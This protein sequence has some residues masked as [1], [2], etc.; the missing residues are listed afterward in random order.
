[1]NESIDGII[2]DK[3]YTHTYRDSYNLQ[4]ECDACEI[5][6]STFQVQYPDVVTFLT[7][8]GIDPIYPLEAMNFSDDDEEYTYQ[9]CVYYCVKG[10][11]PVDKMQKK[12]GEV[13]VTLRN[14]T[15][16]DEAYANTAMKQ[17]YF[18]IELEGVIIY[19]HSS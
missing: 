19:H 12:I 5:F 7:Q 13:N 4:C 9:Y 6:R 1:M 8:F 18:I 2:F 16:A 17:P 10:K 15:I 11:L 3:K 14:W